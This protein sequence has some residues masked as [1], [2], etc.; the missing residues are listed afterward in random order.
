MTAPD[1]P[2]PPRLCSICRGAD[3]IAVFLTAFQ[4]FSTASVFVFLRH[5][6]D[7]SLWLLERLDLFPQAAK[8]KDISSPTFHSD[9]NV[10]AVQSVPIVNALSLVH[11]AGA[12]ALFLAVEM[13][14]EGPPPE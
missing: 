11:V 6:T 7:R 1:R 8:D 14:L 5:F 3:A 12:D 2:L 9:F 10:S 4:L 13:F